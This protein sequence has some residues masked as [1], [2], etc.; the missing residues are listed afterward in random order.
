M[1]E[2]YNDKVEESS[3]VGGETILVNRG[4]GVWGVGD[5][6]IMG[7]DMRDGLTISRN[8]GDGSNVTFAFRPDDCIAIL[9]L[10]NAHQSELLE[11]ADGA[12]PLPAEAFG[13]TIQRDGPVPIPANRYEAGT[14]S[15][16]ESLPLRNDHGSSGT[17]ETY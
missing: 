7:Y 9:S 11:G 14:S 16:D 15:I 6:V 1:K 5:Y 2:E 17:T 12:R 3:N 13:V 10:L 4:D 8:A